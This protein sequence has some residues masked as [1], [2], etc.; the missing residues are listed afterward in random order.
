MTPEV[1]SSY[2][3]K[4]KKRKNLL[5]RVVVFLVLAFC[6]I[7]LIT[8]VR[9][10]IRTEVVYYGT[11]EDKISTDGYLLRNE[12]VIASPSDGMLSSVAGEGERVNKGTRIAAVFAGKVDEALQGRLASINERIAALQKGGMKGSLVVGDAQQ[13]DAV[14][15]KTVEDIIGAVYRGE[16][17]KTA[18]YKDDLD[19]LIAQRT[20]ERGEPVPESDKLERL[21][22]EKA[23]LEAGAGGGRA[24]IYAP[25]AGVF[26]SVIDGF[27]GYFD[28]KD[29]SAITPDVLQAAD[30]VKLAERKNAQKGAPVIKIIDNYAWYY[31]AV[32]DEGWAADLKVGAYVRLRFPDISGKALDAN[33]DALSE[34]KDGKVTVVISCSQYDSD[35]YSLRRV[36][37]D[38]IKKTYS[39]FKVPKSAIRM[40]DDGGCGVYILKEGVPR[41]R[42]VEVLHTGNDYVVVAENNKLE[43]PLLLYDE[44]I[45]SGNSVGDGLGAQP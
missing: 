2:R 18:E 27:E 9:E 8:I 38:I 37:A 4:R 19:S 28:L 21:L 22:A 6:L 44:V 42:Q 16:I 14:M 5:L 32:V 23:Q 11:L 40:P 31:A 34:V 30:G 10:P 20:K 13:V 12:Y 7:W 15:T 41:F 17:E 25:V 33:I 43:N 3:K 39:G 36:S 1:E 35:I 29:R 45:V 26:S 24:D